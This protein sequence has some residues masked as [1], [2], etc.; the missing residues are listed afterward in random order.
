MR[1]KDK[2]RTK[3]V[4]ENKSLAAIEAVCWSAMGSDALSSAVIFL[5]DGIWT[6]TRFFHRR[7]GEAMYCNFSWFLLANEQCRVSIAPQA[8]RRQELEEEEKRKLLPE[9]RKRARE[10]YLKERKDKKLVCNPPLSHGA[11]IAPFPGV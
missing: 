6:M 7:S 8:K 11:M 4:V 2:G 9:L 1:E 3:N 10:K 5:R